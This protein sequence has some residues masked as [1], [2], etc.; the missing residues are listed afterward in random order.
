MA[1]AFVQAIF[2]GEASEL[3]ERFQVQVDRYLIGLAREMKHVPFGPERVFGYLSGL[4]R[5]A[6]N[7]R[8]CLAGRANRIEPTLLERRL[9]ESY[10]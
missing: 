9:R 2:A 8:L 10:A 3:M 1:E 4:A 6:H 5:Q 7:L